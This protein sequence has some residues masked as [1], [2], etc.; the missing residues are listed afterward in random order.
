MLGALDAFRELTLKPGVGTLIDETVRLE[1]TSWFILLDRLVGYNA[2]SGIS[3]ESLHATNTQLI[4]AR[5]M[6][7][8]HVDPSIVFTTKGVVRLLGEE[9]RSDIRR[10]HAET[11]VRACC[12]ESS[13]SAD[14]SRLD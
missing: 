2:A 1:L 9:T 12:S 4:Y 13:T 10:S 14:N 5:V 3:D 8:S 7:R 6:R 11:F